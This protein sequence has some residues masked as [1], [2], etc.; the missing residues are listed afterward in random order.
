MC[1][2]VYACARVCVCVCKLFADCSSDKSF[3]ISCLFT[4]RREW[5]V[6][7]GDMEVDWEGGMGRWREIR[8]SQ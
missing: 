5:M 8:Y 1:V 2:C 4:E 6:E 7:K 3:F